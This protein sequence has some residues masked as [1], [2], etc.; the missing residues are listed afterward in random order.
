VPAKSKSRP[1]RPFV[2]LPPRFEDLPDCLI[3]EA[4]AF[5]RESTWLVWKKIRLGVYK[6]Y[7][8]GKI[9]KVS[10]ASLK[11]DR[12]RAMSAPQTRKRLP[13]R[14]RKTP[15]TINPELRPLP[16]EG[17]AAPSSVQPQRARRPRP[18]R[19]EAAR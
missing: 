11:A 12:E 18:P 7:K 9:T 15:K 4:A 13:G 1:R 8:D 14:P 5:R 16:R 6:A 2:A 19:G 17:T 3:P 10:V